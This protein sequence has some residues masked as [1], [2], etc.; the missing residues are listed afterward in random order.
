MKNQT[1]N[2]TYNDAI[3]E[4][5]KVKWDNYN[6]YHPQEYVD[7]CFDIVVDAT[8]IV[9][10][11]REHDHDT[12]AKIINAMLESGHKFKYIMQN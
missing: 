11:M 7:A 6:I 8:S 10:Y 2:P 3:K 12:Y 1:Y 4:L 9:D 5:C